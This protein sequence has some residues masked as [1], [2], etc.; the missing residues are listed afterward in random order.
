MDQGRQRFLL[1]IAPLSGVSVAHVC[2]YLS[3]HDSL[4]SI[5]GFVHGLV[6]DSG[7]TACE[8]PHVAVQDSGDTA[9]DS[10]YGLVQDSGDSSRAVVHLPVRGSFV[11]TPSGMP[12]AVLACHALLYLVVYLGI[13]GHQDSDSIRCLRPTTY[14]TNRRT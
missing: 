7:D 6:Q 12:T 9:Q 14:P 4:D 1:R 2:V 8:L 3:L 11:A 10:A 5:H 13:L